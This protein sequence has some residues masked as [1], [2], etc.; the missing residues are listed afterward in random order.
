[1]ARPHIEVD[2]HTEPGERATRLLCDLA[3][4]TAPH[5]VWLPPGLTTPGPAVQGLFLRCQRPGLDREH[6]TGDTAA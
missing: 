4:G 5:V 6:R 2:P 3:I 1:M